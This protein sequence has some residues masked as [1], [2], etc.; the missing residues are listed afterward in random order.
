MKKLLLIGGGGHARSLIEAMGRDRFAGYVANEAAD[1]PL[2][3]LGNDAEAIA[4]CSPADY[5]IILG[6]GFNDRCRLSLRRKVLGAFSAYEA[7]NAIAPSAIVTPGTK[8]GDGC[9]IMHRAVVN[10]SLLG[11]HCVVNTGA[12]IEHDCRIGENVFIG[13]GAV[14]CG[15]V[16]VGNDVFIGAGAVVR[17]CVTIAEGISVAMGAIVTRSLTE[18]G[19]YAG[20]PAK[21]TNRKTEQ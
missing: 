10:R 3:Y 6:L 7:E 5:D 16:T 9:C 15:E 13:P 11:K 19:V 8:F 18:P 1:L 20:N 4:T 17:N 21:L 12:I 2:P 14:I